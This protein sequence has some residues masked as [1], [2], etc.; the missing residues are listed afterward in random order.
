M[1]AELD[2]WDV[3]KGY[4]YLDELKIIN[5][6]KGMLPSQTTLSITRQEPSY[7]NVFLCKMKK[8]LKNQIPF[9]FNHEIFIA[10]W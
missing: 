10:C 2:G 6:A 7:I 8:K 5:P 3:A 9:S 4:Y 1:E